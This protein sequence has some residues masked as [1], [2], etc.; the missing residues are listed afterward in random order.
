[1]S[2]AHSIETSMPSNRRRSRAGRVTVLGSG[3]TG[4]ASLTWEIFI[5][6]PVISPKS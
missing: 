3:F 5:E 4:H 2:P 6:S 1:M